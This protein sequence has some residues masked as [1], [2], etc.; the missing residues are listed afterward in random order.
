MSTLV[1]GFHSDF[2]VCFLHYFVLANLATSSIRVKSSSMA[3]VVILYTTF[4]TNQE[5]PQDDL[6]HDTADEAFL[7]M[8]N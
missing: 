3:N 6:I 4:K 5:T 8:Y 7:F 1:P 2:S